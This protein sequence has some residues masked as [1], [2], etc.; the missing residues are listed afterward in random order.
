MKVRSAARQ[1]VELTLKPLERIEEGPFDKIF[2]ECRY[3]TAFWT[4]SDDTAKFEPFGQEEV[5]IGVEGLYGCSTLMI[6][7]PRGAYVAHWWEVPDF[8]DKSGQQLKA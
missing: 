8:G 6:V 5:N 7:S 4:D 3:V 1:A 2:D